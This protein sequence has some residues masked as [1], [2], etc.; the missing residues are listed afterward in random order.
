ALGSALL[1]IVSQHGFAD[2]LDSS[3]VRIDPGRIAAQVVSGIGFIGA[4]TILIQKQFVR[5]LTTAAGLWATSGIGLAVGGGMYWIGVCA[6]LLTLVGLEFLTI[7]FRNVG[8]HSSYLVFS[9]TDA[10][11]LKRVTNELRLK[12]YR[13]TN[14]EVQRELLE[15]KEIFRVSMVIKTK[16]YLDESELFLFMQN[17]PDLTLE[18]LS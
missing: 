10:E 4:G 13:I 14:Y 3:G 18:R 12:R 8:E 7:V 15:H 6:M 5:G 16:R 2:V 9:T 11:N 1:M 17:L